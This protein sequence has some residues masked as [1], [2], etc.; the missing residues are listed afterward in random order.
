[1]TALVC[2]PAAHIGRTSAQPSMEAIEPGRTWSRE[3]ARARCHLFRS[4]GLPSGHAC[5]FPDRPVI[6]PPTFP[7]PAGLALLSHPDAAPLLR[8]LTVGKGIP[9]LVAGW[10]LAAYVCLAAG[11]AWALLCVVTDIPAYDK[12]IRVV[13]LGFTMLMITAIA[14]ALAA[15]GS[16]T[17]TVSCS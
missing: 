10:L 12:I 15:Q 6:C 2:V 11:A 13:I 1:V 7:I 4:R 17:R 14:I 9:H 3:M 16:Q 5:S 8:G